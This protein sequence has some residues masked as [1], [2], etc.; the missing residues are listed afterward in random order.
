MWRST[1]SNMEPSAAS[2]QRSISTHLPRTSSETAAQYQHT[3]HA[4]D[5]RWQQL[6]REHFSSLPTA[7]VIAADSKISLHINYRNE[8]QR[9][10]PVSMYEQF[11]SRN[12][13]STSNEST[14]VPTG[15]IARHESLYF[16]NNN[17]NNNANH[18]PLTSSAS[19]NLRKSGQQTTMGIQQ[20]QPTNRQSPNELVCYFSFV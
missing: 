11:R 17:S 9:P 15:G 12:I 10:R 5:A 7:D 18:K 20:R 2:I 8:Q 13:A 4:G 3:Q 19:H 6:Q 16:V 1:A 14:D